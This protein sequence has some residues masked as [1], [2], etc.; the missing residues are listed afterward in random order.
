MVG[1]LQQGFGQAGPGHA[2]TG[3]F[4]V[5]AAEAPL[6]GFPGSPMNPFFVDLSGD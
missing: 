1:P 4:R 6:L 2:V 5:F 3:H